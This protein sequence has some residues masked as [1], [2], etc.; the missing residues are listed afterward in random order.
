MHYGTQP[1]TPAEMDETVTH[2]SR[3]LAR[4][5]SFVLIAD[6]SPGQD[7]PQDQ[8]Q[9]RHQAA[10]WMKAN[11]QD[12]TRLVKGQVQIVVNAEQARTRAAALLA[13]A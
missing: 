7:D 10:L 1:V 5:Q 6:G 12:L 2:F 8:A 4:D 11:R 9:A 13:E 3:L